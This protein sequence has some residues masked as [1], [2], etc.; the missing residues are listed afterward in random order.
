LCTYFCL[1][2]AL[3]QENKDLELSGT[4]NIDFRYAHSVRLWDE[5]QYT[6]GV[7]KSKSTEMRNLHKLYQKL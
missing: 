2:Y 4:F 1:A 7:I 5:N 6:F 3:F